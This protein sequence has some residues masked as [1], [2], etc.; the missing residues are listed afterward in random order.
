VASGCSWYLHMMDG[1]RIKSARPVADMERRSAPERQAH[2]L[3]LPPGY[4]AGSAVVL[5][6]L[7]VGVPARVVAD[8][9]VSDSTDA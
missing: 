9:S 8:L 7:A 4:Q 5:A 6:G 1:P 2:R 3:P